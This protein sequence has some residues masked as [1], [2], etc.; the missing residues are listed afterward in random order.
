M[1][2]RKQPLWAKTE[3]KNVWE[4]RMD[5]STWKNI[6][7]TAKIHSKSYSWIVR[8]CV[9]QLSNKKNLRWTKK[10]SNTHKD[11]KLN[12]NNKIH[13]H[14][15]CLY[16]D[17]EMLLRNS[18]MILSTSVSQLIRISIAMFLDRLL[19]EKTSKENLFWYGIKLFSKIAIFRSVKNNTIA[20][21]FHSHKVFLP[22]EYW[23]FG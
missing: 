15:L 3:I 7:S 19:K 14:Q 4:V 10:L 13:R 9:F 12:K 2:C 16:G 21:D 22:K 20:M 8:Y 6:Q 5:L 1:K 17:D 11:I 18:A 23:G